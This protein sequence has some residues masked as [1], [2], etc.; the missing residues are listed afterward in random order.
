MASDITGGV[1]AMETEAARVLDEAKAK[2][3]DILQSAR[4]ESKKMS[5]T[6]LPLDDVKAEC[7]KIVEEANSKAAAETKAAAKQAKDIKSG[8][9]GKVDHY[10]K[11]MASIVVGEKAA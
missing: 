3:S 2:A 8:A 10:A 9:S 6:E 7:V 4:N 1:Q 5:S 11:M